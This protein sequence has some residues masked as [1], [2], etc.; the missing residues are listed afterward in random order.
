MNSAIGA[1][2]AVIISSV[3]I[4]PLLNST[5]IN[6]KFHNT[7]D[8]RNEL[9]HFTISPSLTQSD[10][11]KFQS[12]VSPLSESTE[13]RLINLL[14]QHL[15]EKVSV[16]DYFIYKDDVQDVG[17]LLLKLNWLK[18]GTV[19]GLR[20]P[21][22]LHLYPNYIRNKYLENL[23]FNLIEDKI[24]HIDASII[25]NDDDFVES[26]DNYKIGIN[27]FSNL[28]FKNSVAW[29]ILE[30][31]ISLILVSSQLISVN[32]TANTLTRIALFIVPAVGTFIVSYLTYSS[33]QKKAK[34]EVATVIKTLN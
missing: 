17:R 3:I 31:F 24:N 11:Q 10:V 8:W 9:Y 25:N 2:I 13:D 5:Q 4:S 23:I 16:T 22:K 15:L 18:H 19:S 27:A 12:L 20:S 33:D 30:F 29:I 6:A 28:W 14:C 21:M 1:V 32:I 7:F 26:T 34:S